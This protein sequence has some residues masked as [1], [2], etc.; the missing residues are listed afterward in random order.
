VV[1]EAQASRTAQYMAFF[2]ALEAARPAS[3]RLFHDPLARAFLPGGLRLA[4]ELARAAPLGALLRAYID[5]RWP[6]ARTSAV[7]RTRF[8]D[9]AAELAIRSG[10]EQAVVLGAG[11]DARAY[12]LAALDRVSVFEVDHPATSTAKRTAVAAALGVLPRHVRF[13]PIDF[14]AEPLGTAMASAGFDPGRRTLVIWEGV[15]N[16]LTEAAVDETLRW[17]AGLAAGSRVLFTYVH[18]QVLDAP[19]TFAGTARL[20]AALHAADERWTFGLEPAEVPG[21]LARR[22]LSLDE[23]VGA[24]AY[25]ARYFGQAAAGMCGYEFYRIASAHV[26]GPV[27]H[28]AQPGVA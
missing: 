5:R 27:P 18:R 1:R 6:G 22:G 14:N 8:L 7:A 19:Q 28:A 2:R 12:R 17:C 21:F 25:R 24:A 4:A 3:H 9:D 23:D 20:F 13:V 15:T 11:F 10:A 26:P 16:Y